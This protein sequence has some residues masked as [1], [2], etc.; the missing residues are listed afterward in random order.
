MQDEILYVGS[1]FVLTLRFCYDK[2]DLN[3]TRVGGLY[4]FFG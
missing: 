3:N 4:G 2:M 1:F